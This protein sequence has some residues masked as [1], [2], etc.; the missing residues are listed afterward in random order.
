MKSEQWLREQLALA[1]KQYEEAENETVVV[2]AK[3]LVKLN[4]EILKTVLEE[5]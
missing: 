4:I 2:S 5:A 3:F 1:Q